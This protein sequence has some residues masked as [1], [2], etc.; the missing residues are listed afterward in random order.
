MHRRRL[1]EL[2]AHLKGSVCGLSLQLVKWIVPEEGCGYFSP[3]SSVPK[4]NKPRQPAQQHDHWQGNIALGQL[5]RNKELAVCG[6]RVQHPACG[7][8]RDACLHTGLGQETLDHRVSMH[9]F[10]V[11]DLSGLNSRSQSHARGRWAVGFLP[12]EPTTHLHQLSCRTCCLAS[13]G[14][15]VPRKTVACFWC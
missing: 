6:A 14:R 7:D 13:V 11:L 8:S 2:G 3:D 12:A 4:V 10:A 15:L 9:C 1:L 5:P